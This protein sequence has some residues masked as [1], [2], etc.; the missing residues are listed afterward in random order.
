L[1]PSFGGVRGGAFFTFLIIS[2]FGFLFSSCDSGGKI[3][4]FDT[5]T[6]GE[7]LIGSDECLA[8]IVKEELDV[9]MGL[10]L[11]A[12]ITPI[13]TGENELFNLLLSDSIR[14]IVAARNLTDREKEQIKAMN[15][16]PRTQMIA[17]DGIALI[18]N[19]KNTD[20]LINVSLLQ[21][22]MT[23][24]ITDWNQLNPS[25]SVSGKIQV[26]FD[27]QSSSTL[28]FINDSIVRGKP[29]S[30]DLRALESNPAVI[31]YVAKTPHA[32]G[33]IGVNWISNPYDSTKLSFDETIRVM[34]VG[35]AAAVNED[36]TYKPFPVFLN[37]KSYPLTREIYIILTDYRQT[38]PAGFVKFGAGDAG[39]RIIMKAG[40]VTATCPTRE[41]YIKEDF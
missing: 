1:F 35:R 11:E 13:Y 21:K 36:N 40:L 25:P 38:V 8:P 9:F 15:L 37:N 39:Q 28:R 6:S 24:E 30:P 17:K 16:L 23:G 26:V 19:K 7:A 27:N 34:S 18:I 33:V 22:I 14:L 2:C 10:N 3:T 41:I 12:E 20:S 5:E 29:L 31:E 32:I 4:R